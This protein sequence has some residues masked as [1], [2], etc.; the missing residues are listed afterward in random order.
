MKKKLYVALLLTMTILSACGG[1][2]GGDAN[3]PATQP[4]T[5]TVKLESTGT[6]TIYGIDV[7]VAL[8]AGVTLKSATNPPQT[9]SGVVTA[10]GVAASNTLVT[11][12][13]TAASGTAPAKARVLLV[14][15]NGFSAGEYCTVNA[16]IAAGYTPK[17]A[18][19]SIINFTASDQNG[20][21]LSGL[22]PSFTAT[23]L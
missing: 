21:V 18:D 11:A 10:T 23:V 14:N 6:G 9:D 12:V 3:S 22:T 13:Y 8:P 1:G 17:A 19:F 5:A 16:E 15:A 7:T 2:S 20:N 4:T